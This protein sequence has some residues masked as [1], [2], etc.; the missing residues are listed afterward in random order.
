MVLTERAAQAED[1]DDEAAKGHEQQDPVDELRAQG[2]IEEREL[3]EKGMTHATMLQGGPHA[4]LDVSAHREAHLS[5]VAT[6]KIKKRLGTMPP[7]HELVGRRRRGLLSD[8][9][10]DRGP[11]RV[12]EHRGRPDLL[13]G[14]GDFDAHHAS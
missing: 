3:D 11:V 10:G 9:A 2:Q 12:A 8:R 6:P 7:R 4:G 13:R 1:D 5:R 14:A